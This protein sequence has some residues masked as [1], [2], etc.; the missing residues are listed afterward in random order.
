MPKFSKRINELVNISDGPYDVV[1]DLCCDHGLIGEAFINANKVKS[2]LIYMD[3][4]VSIMTKLETKIKASDITKGVNISFITESCKTHNYDFQKKTLFI[5]AGIGG[6]LSIEILEQIQKSS[7]HLNNAT[8]LISAHENMVNLRE[9]LSKSRLGLIKE[10]LVFDKGKF[11]EMLLVNSSSDKT[12][13]LCGKDMW[14]SPENFHLDYIDDR[15]TYFQLKNRYE[16]SEKFSFIINEL[17]SLRE[18][19]SSLIL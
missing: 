5:L 7:N 19:V 4:V 12:V 10:K 2:K 1:W 9:Y 13:S 17:K 11:Y 15:L 14:H 16:S 8:F 3:Q 18:Q 6:E